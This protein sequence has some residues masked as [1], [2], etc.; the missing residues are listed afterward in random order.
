MK[1]QAS[2]PETVVDL[3]MTRSETDG[4]SRYRILQN[5][6]QGFTAIDSCLATKHVSVNF[7]VFK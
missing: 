3:N 6:Y 1:K 7:H 5:H 2:P 4:T